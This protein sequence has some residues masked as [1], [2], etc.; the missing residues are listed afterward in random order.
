MIYLLKVLISNVLNILTI[1]FGLFYKVQ[2]FIFYLLF[3]TKGL[4]KD[5]YVRISMDS[6]PFEQTF[7]HPDQPYSKINT[8]KKIIITQSKDRVDIPKFF[9]DNGTD[10]PCSFYVDTYKNLT[11]L[12]DAISSWLQLQ[13]DINFD[14]SSL[15]IIQTGIVYGLW[16]YLIMFNLRITLYWFLGFNQFKQPALSFTALFDWI[17]QIPLPG[18]FTIDFCA[19]FLLTVTTEIQ[20]YV[21]GLVFTMPYLPSEA[22]SGTISDDYSIQASLSKDYYR[23]QKKNSSHVDHD[24]LIFR[25]IPKLWEERGIPNA[26]REFWFYYKP[27]DLINTLLQTKYKLNVFP[28]SMLDA[29][30]EGVEKCTNLEDFYNLTF[31]FMTADGIVTYTGGQLHQYRFLLYNELKTNENMYIFTEPLYNGD[32]NLDLN[33]TLTVNP[34]DIFEEVFKNINVSEFLS[35]PYYDLAGVF[36]N[37]SKGHH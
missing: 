35:N 11:F 37:I 17:Y 3:D 33:F 26:V 6:L 23:L 12:P 30:K 10:G 18:I 14:T 25:D 27:Q 13:F 29:F 16:I 34:V 9:Y 1:I 24:I 21:A 28:D 2:A 4:T 36:H 15:E 32:K 19:V 22:I 5:R 31:K 8:I 20:N 7:K